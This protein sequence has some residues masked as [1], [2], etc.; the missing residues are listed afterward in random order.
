MPFYLYGRLTQFVHVQ[1]LRAADISKLVSKSWKL[2]EKSERAKWEE[3]ARI[4]KARYEREKA[5]YK[6]PWKVPTI[7]FDDAPK[8][9]M[10]AYLAFSNERRRAIAESNPF[11]TNAEI[12]KLLSKLWKECPADVKQAYRDKEACK[13]EAFK[14]YRAEWE[15]KKQRDAGIDLPTTDDDNQ[16]SDSGEEGLMEIDVDDLATP[17]D[18]AHFRRKDNWDAWTSFSSLESTETAVMQPKMTEY[19][20]SNMSCFSDT[21]DP[22]AVEYISNSLPDMSNASLR[23]FP[24]G[25]LVL[26]KLID[27]TRKSIEDYSLDDLLADEELFEDFS[28]H[29][30]PTTAP[31]VGHAV[32]PWDHGLAGIPPRVGAQTIGG[33][34]KVSSL[35]FIQGARSHIKHV[36]KKFHSPY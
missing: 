8:K 6:G 30:V 28:P 1:K 21:A 13:R 24:S 29:D 16:R 32:L 35:A 9:P 10:S 12:S 2:L 36:R 22:Q 23:D 5:S 15:R 34:T 4:D 25:R 17:Y 20:P 33:Q 31:F 3:M 27:H 18:A 7:V 19:T 14:K 11:L 26:P